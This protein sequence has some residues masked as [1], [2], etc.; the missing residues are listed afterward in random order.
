MNE[1]LPVRLDDLI[2]YVTQQHPE[3]D[4]LVRLS[5]A[6][7][8]ADRLG[9]QSDH[10]IGHFVDQA[11]RSGASWT[12]IGEHM[13]VTKQAA[14]KRFVAN[15]PAAIDPGMMTRFTDRARA[16]VSHAQ[17]AARDTGH[18]HIESPHLLLGLLAEPD[19]LAAKVIE[20]HDV[21]LDQV[22]RTAK[23]RLGTPDDTQPPVIPP[24]KSTLE[25]IATLTLREAL[26]MGHNY[27]GTEHILLGILASGD[28]DGAR[29]LNDLGVTH[30]SAKNRIEELL[31]AWIPKA[32]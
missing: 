27:I 22:E 31:S 6:V 17:L 24:D 32:D 13:G 2:S 12:Q 3:A 28:S 10:L 11:R 5:D 7:L 14:Q 26:G 15:K 23:G 30:E 8:L 9:E 1:P 4:A 18:D 25:I 21:P 20:A 29:I 16:V 19:G